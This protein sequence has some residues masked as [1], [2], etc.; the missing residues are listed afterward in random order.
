MASIFRRDEVLPI[1]GPYLTDRVRRYA[2]SAV[3]R[4]RDPGARA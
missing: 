2:M 1:I 3:S 4:H